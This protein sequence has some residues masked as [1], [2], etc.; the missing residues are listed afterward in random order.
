MSVKLMTAIM[1]SDTA[2]L[3]FE[4]PNKVKI[5]KRHTVI[6]LSVCFCN[7]CRTAALANS[8]LKKEYIC[9]IILNNKEDCLKWKIMKT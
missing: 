7:M 9:A 8:A 3:V 6:T 4:Y 5:S 1:C 2:L